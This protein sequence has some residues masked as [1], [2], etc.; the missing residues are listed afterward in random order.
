MKIVSSPR[1]GVV[2]EADEGTFLFQRAPEK[3]N[4]GII[5]RKR[6]SGA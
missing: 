4:G 1:D 5:S 6:A 2:W 3:P